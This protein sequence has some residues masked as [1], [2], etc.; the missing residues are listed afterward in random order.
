MRGYV[1]ACVRAFS[2][3]S[4]PS[5]VPAL[6][7]AFFSQVL[8]RFPQVF[9]WGDGSVSQGIIFRTIKEER[10]APVLKDLE[11]LHVEPE[12]WGRGA[13]GAFQSLSSSSERSLAWSITSSPSSDGGH[14]FSALG[15]SVPAGIGR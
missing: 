7:G 13:G 14:F 1:R 5:L 4:S 6:R 3:H 11:I 9:F 15:F 8:L 10:V 12:A 2:V